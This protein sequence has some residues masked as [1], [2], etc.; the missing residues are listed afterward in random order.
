MQSIKQLTKKI[1]YNAIF[2]DELNKDRFKYD[3]ESRIEF[4]RE[5]VLSRYSKTI[6]NIDRWLKELNQSNEEDIKNKKIIILES[7]VKIIKKDLQHS[8]LAN[9]IYDKDKAFNKTLKNNVLPLKYKNSNGEIVKVKRLENIEI[10]LKT[11]CVVSRAWKINSWY[12][13]LIRKEK[14]KKS[15]NHQGI[16][17]KNIDIISIENGFHGCTDAW[18]NRDEALMV[19]NCYDDTEILKNIYSDGFNWYNNYDDSFIEPVKD[20]RIAVIFYLIK[21]INEILA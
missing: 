19:A 11:V 12:E 16:Y 15:N 5:L 2:K 6:Y 1:I 21:M 3:E 7:F 17:F 8:Y 14:F 9:F 20:Y 4:E 13:T 10:D 18:F